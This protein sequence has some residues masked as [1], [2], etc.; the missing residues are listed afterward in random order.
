MRLDVSREFRGMIEEESKTGQF[1]GAPAVAQ[2]AE[3]FRSHASIAYT[4]NI[5]AGPL[6]VSNLFTEQDRTAGSSICSAS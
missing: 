3:W 4:G 2:P 6:D 1:L 5:F